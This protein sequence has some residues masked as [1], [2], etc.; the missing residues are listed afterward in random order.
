VLHP[1]LPRSLL[2]SDSNVKC[3]FDAYIYLLG[4]KQLINGYFRDRIQTNLQAHIPFMWWLCLEMLNTVRNR[5][6]HLI[7][8]MQCKLSQLYTYLGS[9]GSVVRSIVVTKT[10]T[11]KT[12]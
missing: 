3:L 7:E 8:G 5:F 11:K 10:H 1:S 2:V 9:G 12:R 4:D 6:T